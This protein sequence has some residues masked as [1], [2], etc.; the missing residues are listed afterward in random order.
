[1]LDR[2]PLLPLARL[3][4]ALVWLYNGLWCKL[5]GG[6]PDHAEIVAGAAAD[7]GLP[8]A[9]VL[10]A[11]GGAETAIALWVL[12]GRAPRAAAWTQTLLLVAM[13]GAGLLFG[14]EAIPRPGGLVVHNLVFLVLVWAVAASGGRERR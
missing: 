13:N 14:A 7:V 12:S 5:L 9:P 8:A 2:A 1:M 11:L 6:C 3:A 10:W 4:I